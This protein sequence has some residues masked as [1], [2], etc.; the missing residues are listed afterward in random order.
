MVCRTRVQRGRD[1]TADCPQTHH[2]RRW[3]FKT[4]GHL[5]V[6]LLTKVRQLG[7]LGRDE[8]QEGQPHLDLILNEV[9]ICLLDNIP[10][11]CL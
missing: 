10:V 4:H 11:N 2:A 9:E 3:P 8:A 1:T 6:S 5:P 7:P